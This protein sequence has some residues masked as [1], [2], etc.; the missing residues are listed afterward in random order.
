V[1]TRENLAKRTRDFT[2]T[3]EIKAK[4]YLTEI[5]KIINIE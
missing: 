3:L 4:F 1:I 5:F 2:G